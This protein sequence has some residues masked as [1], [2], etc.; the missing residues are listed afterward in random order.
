MRPGAAAVDEAPGGTRTGEVAD[1]ADSSTAGPDTP[2]A[3]A[4]KPVVHYDA[5]GRPETVD[6]G[7]R[8]HTVSTRN[9]QISQLTRSLDPVT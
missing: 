6:L 8:T 2:E 4:A 7:D 3:P 5:D 9:D 1:G